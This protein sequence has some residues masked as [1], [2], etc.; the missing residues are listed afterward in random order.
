MSPESDKKVAEKIPAIMK[1][2]QERLGKLSHTE[3]R[4]LAFIACN[5]VG[6]FALGGQDYT[7]LEEAVVGMKTGVDI[8]FEAYEDAKNGGGALDSQGSAT[9]KEDQSDKTYFCPTI[10]HA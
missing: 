9:Q 3:L 10:G 4:N 6:M 5:R 2:I 7:S 8:V 1:E